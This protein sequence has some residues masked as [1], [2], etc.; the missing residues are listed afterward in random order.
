MN[1]TEDRDVWV[2]DLESNGFLNEATVIWCGVF[3]NITTLEEVSLSVDSGINERLP[4]LLERMEAVVFHNGV[5][6]DRPLIK[7]ILKYNLSRDKVI[8]SLILSKL[9]NPDRKVPRGWK[10]Q[11]KP[12]SI[13]AWGMRFG[14][15]KPEH[16][17]WSRYSDHMLHRCR[18][19]VMINIK[20]YEAIIEELRS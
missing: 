1:Y 8:D 5:A 7:K 18:E 20:T 9:S 4:P 17:D 15:K 19:D 6:F 14:I 10:G 11:H 13:E 3:I 2:G 16:E 12:H